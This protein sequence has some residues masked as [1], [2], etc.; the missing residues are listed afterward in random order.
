MEVNIMENKCCG[1]H[2]VCDCPD[3]TYV[4]MLYAQVDYLESYAPEDKEEIE[5]LKDEILS[6]GYSI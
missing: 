3:C 4:N 6:L 2:E 1:Y 5:R